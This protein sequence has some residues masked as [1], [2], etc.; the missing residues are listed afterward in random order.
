MGHQDAERVQRVWQQAENPVEE[1][2]AVLLMPVSDSSI[3][4]CFEYVL[5]ESVKVLHL[6]DNGIEEIIDVGRRAEDGRRPRVLLTAHKG[7]PHVEQSDEV[8]YCPRDFDDVRSAP[9]DTE[10]WEEVRDL[11][12][13]ML[14]AEVVCMLRRWHLLKSAERV[15][16]SERPQREDCE[17]FE[18]TATPRK[19]GTAETDGRRHC[20][21]E[22]S[23][24]HDYFLFVLVSCL[25]ASFFLVSS[26]FACSRKS[27]S[28]QKRATPHSP[29]T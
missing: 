14:L 11:K 16:E 6:L 10:R 22:E 4:L 24:T 9:G 28:A 27:A 2:T 13:A 20:K 12:R 8:A 18:S 3:P 7:V 23:I 5:K 21:T 26:C 25:S 1:L 19:D 29:N 15:I 17:K